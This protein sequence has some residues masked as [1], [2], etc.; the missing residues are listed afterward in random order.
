MKNIL[1]I[2]QKV[3]AKD[4][5]LGF[6]VGWLHEFSKNFEKVF[7]ITLEKGA[8]ELPKNVFVYSLG[9]ENS[10][11][12]IARALTFYKLLFQLV[13]KT[14]GVFAHMSPVFAI[15]SWPVAVLYRKRIILWY[16]HRS[17][18]GR[19]KLAEKL[20]YK[21][22][23]ASKESLKLISSKVI[24]IGHGIQVEQFK[25]VRNWPNKK[26]EILSVGRISRI[27]DYETLLEA[28]KILKDKDLNFQVKIVGQPIMVP[29]F[30]YQKLLVSLQEKL[31]LK[32]VVEFVGFVPYSQMVR[33]YKETDLVIGLTPYGGIDKVILEGMASGCLVLTSNEANRRY[34]GHYA[35]NLIFNHHDS[36]HLAHKIESLNC[37]PAEQKK[38]MSE[39]LVRSVEQNH[40][41]TNLINR[42]SKLYE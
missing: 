37:M 7:V 16:L 34:F 29:D 6:F 12:K 15:A 19:L 25:T 40:N 36:V 38:E 32:D 30:K 2:T 27:K 20:C 24:E 4:D 23:T 41:L 39:F 8:Y 3:N 28:A 33:Y 18:T 13:P 26:L 17:V 10:N 35:D 22:V 1:I 21:I 11:L 9:K 42:I 14:D 5:L 31:E